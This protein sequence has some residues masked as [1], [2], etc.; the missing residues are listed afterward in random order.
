MTN[1]FIKLSLLFS[2]LLLLI[3]PLT[4]H[5]QTRVVTGTVL[6]HRGQELPGVSIRLE[7]TTISTISGVDGT[8]SISFT[9][10]FA[11]PVLLFSHPRQ[12][13]QRLDVSQE[14]TLRVTLLPEGHS[15]ESRRR[16]KRLYATATMTALGTGA[17]FYFS[18][19]NLEDDYPDATANATDIYDKME[20]HEM[21]AM[22]AVGA[23]LPLGVMTLVRSSQ[24][25]RLGKDVHISA[26]PARDGAV[27][28]LSLRF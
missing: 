10:D 5:G 24:Q 25:R 9:A 1:P 21:I 19:V 6:D 26:M 15:Y 16:S 12:T 3:L 20:R 22:I 2:L 11:A 17:Y 23:A 13:T 7:G 27:I 28:G 14:S 18:S 4:L 8:F